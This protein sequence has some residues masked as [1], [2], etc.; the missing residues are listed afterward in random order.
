MPKV[1]LASPLG[2]AESTRG[3]M[4][5]LERQIAGCGYT[6]VNPW[7][8]AVPQQF[9]AAAAIKNVERRRQAFHDVNMKLAARNEKAIRECDVIMAVLDGADVD[10][11]TASEIGFAYALGKRIYG[12][13]GDFRRA[14]D[15]EGSI[16]NLQVEYWI[17]SSGGCIV[18][19]LD[20]LQQRLVESATG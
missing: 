13:R 3:F 6:V 1:Y 8:L 7:G 18:T 9:K 19:S 11:G 12:Y 15:N 17:E 2:F 4:S 10:S 14:G 5:I 20:R 16:V